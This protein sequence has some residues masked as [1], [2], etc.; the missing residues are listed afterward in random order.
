MSEL[1]KLKAQADCA[2]AEYDAAQDAVLQ[3]YQALAEAKDLV[4]KTYDKRLAAMKAY[5]EFGAL[6]AQELF[7]QFILNLARIPPPLRVSVGGG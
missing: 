6:K 5:R 2:Q 1:A 3:A 7:A 4:G